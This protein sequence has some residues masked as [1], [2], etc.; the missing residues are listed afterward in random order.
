MSKKTSWEKL[1]VGAVVL[2]LGSSVRHET[3][4]WRTL[5]PVYDRSK[6]NKCDLCWVYCPDGS[7]VPTED[8]FFEVDLE[9]CKGCGICAKECPVK[10]IVMVKEKE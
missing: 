8:G 4:S 9:H 7:I 3:G 10:A 2:E 1:P 6:C 5:R